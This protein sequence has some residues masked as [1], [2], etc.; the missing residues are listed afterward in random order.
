MWILK[1]AKHMVINLDSTNVS[2]YFQLCYK[3]TQRKPSRT[4]SVENCPHIYHVYPGQGLKLGRSGERCEHHE[5]AS[6]LMQPFMSNLRV[7]W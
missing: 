2:I 3:R 7:E 1:Q 4:I 6:L 5:D